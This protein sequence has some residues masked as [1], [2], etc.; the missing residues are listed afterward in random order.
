[1]TNT[2]LAL[3]ASTAAKLAALQAEHAEITF[4][5]AA[6]AGNE[7]TRRTAILA[8]IESSLTGTWSPKGRQ[9]EIA[10]RLAAFDKQ[11]AA[12]VRGKRADLTARLAVLVKEIEATQR[13]HEVLAA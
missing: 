12:F 13:Y 9:S 4:D 5:L 10:R 11:R 1:M 3:I 7:A 6:I 2:R 8:S